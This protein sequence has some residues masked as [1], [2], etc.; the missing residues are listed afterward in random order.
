MKKQTPPP[1]YWTAQALGEMPL[2]EADATPVQAQAQRQQVEAMAEAL[3]RQRVDPALKLHPLQRRAILQLAQQVQSKPKPSAPRWLL[4]SGWLASSAALLALGFWLGQHP[5]SAFGRRQLAQSAAISPAS[6]SVIDL[7]T[8]AAKAT[9]AA[10]PGREPQR[11]QVVE[12]PALKPQTRSSSAPA[13]AQSTGSEVVV[14]APKSATQPQQ[15]L[16]G[17]APG[18]E[19][20]HSKASATSSP[21]AGRA[22]TPGAHLQL[23]ADRNWVAAARRARDAW[24]L[25]PVKVRPAVAQPKNSLSLAAAPRAG[26]ASKPQQALPAQEVFIHS[27]SAECFA[28]PWNPQLRLL[29]VSIQLPPR[30]AAAEVGGDFPLELEFD[31]R[32]IRNYRRL[33]SRLKTAPS[34]EMAGQ[35]SFWYELEPVSREALAAGR[36]LAQIRLAKG[37]FTTP[38]AGPFDGSKLQVLD[39]GQGWENARAD[40]LFESAVLAWGLLL[41]GGQPTGLN[42]EW[43][44]RLA[45]RGQGSDAGGERQRFLRELDAAIGAAGL[46]LPPPAR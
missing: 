28:C 7:T 31:S 21:P 2:R 44:R 41:E 39:R 25:D 22:P 38:P 35:Q 24:A 30:Q 27:W 15:P 3:K 16:T 10:K 34:L 36:P 11:V 4:A 8:P 5:D 40:Y 9:Q 32:L 33:G 42:H 23:E 13:R 14:A 1:V 46:P 20:N 45:L 19:E 26:L 43:V 12:A 29:R 18:P 6:P 17:A 37:R